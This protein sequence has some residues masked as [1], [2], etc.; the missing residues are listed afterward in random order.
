MKPSEGDKRWTILN[1]PVELVTRIKK[2]AKVNGYKIP[3]AIKELTEKELTTWE[4]KQKEK[5]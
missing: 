2:Y 5:Q 4:K 1:M 3:R